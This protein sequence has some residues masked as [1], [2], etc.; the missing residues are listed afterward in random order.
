MNFFDLDTIWLAFLLFLPAGVA[1]AT[2]VIANRIP[3]L[4][5]W[6]TPLDFGLSW[7]GKRLLGDNK[8]WRG[9]VTGTAIGV[10]TG[11]FICNPLLALGDYAPLPIA[12]LVWLGLGALLGDAIESYIKRRRNRAPGTSWFPFD[13]ID[14]IIG[15]LLCT[16]LF[17]VWDL[18][19]ATWVLVLFFGLH[20]LSA[21]V[22]YLLGLKAKPI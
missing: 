14:Y 3:L 16:M 10:V 19:L 4:N 15:G 22:A 8:S 18:A 11:I 17:G 6:K 1:N 21:Y 13:Q 9:L 12:V 7:R 5:R 20:L 2:P